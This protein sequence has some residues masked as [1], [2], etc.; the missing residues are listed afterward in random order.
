MYSS[1]RRDPGDERIRRAP[2]LIEAVVTHHD[3]LGVP[4]DA[5]AREIIQAY[6]RLSLRWHPDRNLD[7]QIVAEKRFKE[8]NDAYTALVDSETGSLRPQLHKE[9]YVYTGILTE[10]MHKSTTVHELSLTLDELFRGCA[11]VREL[12]RN[13]MVQ[14]D[15]VQERR[16]LEIPI[17]PGWTS[18]TKLLYENEGD[19]VSGGQVADLV[20]EVKQVPHPL[21]KRVGDDIEH[22][23]VLPKPGDASPPKP[24]RLQKLASCDLGTLDTPF[25]PYCDI[26]SELCGVTVT[27]L[28]PHA[29]PA[30]IAESIEGKK[31]RL[32][33]VPHEAWQ[34]PQGKG[35]KLRDQGMTASRVRMPGALQATLG[36]QC[37]ETRD[38]LHSVSWKINKKTDEVAVG[39]APPV[40]HCDRR[41]HM[42]VAKGKWGVVWHSDGNLYHLGSSKP[43]INIGTY[44][45]NDVCQISV[46]AADH[47]LFVFKNKKLI[48]RYG[49]KIVVPVEGRTHGDVH[50]ENEEGMPVYRNNK[51]VGRGDLQVRFIAPKKMTQAE[52]VAKD[53]DE[54]NAG[55]KLLHWLA[56]RKHP[57][58]VFNVNDWKSDVGAS[59]KSYQTKVSLQQRRPFAT[60]GQFDG[61]TFMGKVQPTPS[62]AK[63]SAAAKA[64]RTLEK[65]ATRFPEV[66][67]PLVSIKRKLPAADDGALQ[68]K[69]LKSDKAPAAP[70]VAVEVEAAVEPA[71]TNL[72]DID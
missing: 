31:E 56:E 6:R 4:T 7:N 16:L 20:Y 22:T 46:H 48:F 44:G 25:T 3:A 55:E 28:K 19:Q 71:A 12:K 1:A 72:D 8:I 60:E 32:C 67:K 70:V 36:K 2:I 68:A 69:R 58:A 61:A 63:D 42:D 5:S 50:T 40:T 23:C 64:L 14:G 34:P 17:L 47:Q 45:P 39:F 41:F 43:R 53:L 62:A 59:D 10:G 15:L 37:F 35:I 29:L 52:T 65:L 27:L 24:L 21:Y 66:H 26:L 51:V 33:V 9:E 38:A 11:K 30:D 13:R 54:E 18:G 57:A 49:E